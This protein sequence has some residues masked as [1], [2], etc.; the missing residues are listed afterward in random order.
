MGSKDSEGKLFG[1]S[2][3]EIETK[4]VKRCIGIEGDN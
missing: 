1:V 4:R 2:N 3:C